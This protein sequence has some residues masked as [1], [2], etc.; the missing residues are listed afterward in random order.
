[1]AHP[2]GFVDLRSDTVT[3]PTAAMRRAMADA[4]VG[5]DQYG[6]D[7]TVRRLEEASA[8]YLGK[9]AAC[10]VA[11]GTMGNL[12]AI[13]AHC[14]RGDEVLLGDECHV[15]WYESGGAAALGGL[16]FNKLRT[17]SQGRLDPQEISDMIRAV[18]AGY[19][20]TGLLCLE[21]TH[22]R[23][24]GTV[25]P[26]AYFAAVRQITEP[27]G[28][29]IH[30]DGARIFNAAAAL[31]LP[32][33][34]LV[35]DVDS[36]QFCF[37]KALAAPVGSIVVGTEEFITRVRAQRKIVGGAMRQ[38]GVI[39][40]AALVGLQEMM[41]RLPEDHRRARRLAEGLAQLPGITIDLATV[42]SNIVIF[43]PDP[44][45][46]TTDEFISG[47]GEGGVRVSNYG[48]RGLRMVTHY[49]ITDDD[50]EQALQV[51]SRLLES[52]PVATQAATA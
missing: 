43:K 51:A 21:N 41:D 32:A 10:Y 18:R 20:R 19:P 46:I 9:E 15:L 40:A 47:M 1:M 22:N 24:G 49:Q 26:P 30:L 27:R 8:A 48:L 6:E 29:P 28:V 44:V 50:I 45:R 52:R 16:P 3:Q 35:R 17:D 7:P 25:L 13:L 34:E 2:D 12:I 23:C 36:V 39:A 5:D 11:S 14:G 42:Q 33:S 31:N 4:E 37:S 38:A